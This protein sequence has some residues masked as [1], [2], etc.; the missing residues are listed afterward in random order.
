MDKKNQDIIKSKPTGGFPP[1]YICSVENKKQQ[2]DNKFR[3]FSK[4]D[5]KITVSL[6]DFLGERRTENVKPFIVL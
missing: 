2:E 1:L 6:K 3:G 5:E 4:E